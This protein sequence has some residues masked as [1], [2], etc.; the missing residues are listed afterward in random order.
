[1]KPFEYNRANDLDHAA[2]LTS[3]GARPIA[4]GTNLLDLM[5][6]EIETPDALVDINRVPLGG[7]EPDGDELRIGALVTNSACAADERIRRDY[8]VLARAILAGA[9]FQLRNKA[10]TAGNLCQRTRCYYFYNTEMPCNKREPGSGC[11]AIGGFNRIHAVLG[12]SDACIATYPGDMAVA[13]CALNAT[14]EIATAE[15]HTR[16]VPVRA[17]HRLPDDAPERDNVLEP[18]EVITAVVLPAPPGGKHVY[19]KVRDR[20]SYAFA[21]VSIAAV[22]RMDGGAI[23]SAALAFGGLAHKPWHDERVDALLVGEVPSDALFDKAADLLLDGA[24]GHGTNDFKI[25]MARR[26][27]K[28]VLREVTGDAE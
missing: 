10:T 16:S 6:L 3:D 18:G 24:Q 8:P 28:A 15:G 9:T 1:M 27:L 14:V 13:L 17:F 11:S 22:V 26:T 5:K 12:A 7:I 19:R 21:L 25:P 20:S 2:R 23:A 4:G